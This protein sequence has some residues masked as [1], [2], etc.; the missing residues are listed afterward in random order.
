MFGQPK[1]GKSVLATTVGMSLVRGTPFAGLR[2]NRTAALHVAPEGAPAIRAATVP[3]IG[4]GTSPG[5]EP[6]FVYGIHEEAAIEV[7]VSRLAARLG[8][9][10][11][12]V[13]GCAVQRAVLI[14]LARV[15]ICAYR[16]AGA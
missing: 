5:A 3:Y 4:D 8:D 2:T 11:A 7:E 9:Q 16:I 12:A 10:K 15:M 14:R 13:T 6:Y 1:S